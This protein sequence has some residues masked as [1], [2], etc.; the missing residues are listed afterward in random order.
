MYVS[1]PGFGACRN[2]VCP[3]QKIEESEKLGDGLHM[4]ISSSPL[5]GLIHAI[6]SISDNY[7]IMV[8]S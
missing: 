4:R 7:V 5:C 6:P 8:C 1:D 3:R 2:H